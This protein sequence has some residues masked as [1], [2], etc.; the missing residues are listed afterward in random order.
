MTYIFHC[1]ENASDRFR[2]ILYGMNK[3]TNTEVNQ[4]R[5]K[6]N[7]DIVVNQQGKNSKV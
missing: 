7:N 4:F 1:F 3:G 2:T 5:Y 6:L